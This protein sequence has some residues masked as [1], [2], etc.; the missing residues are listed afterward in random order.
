M[1]RATPFHVLASAWKAF[2]DDPVATVD[3]G[4]DG[5]AAVFDVRGAGIV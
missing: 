1:Q 2:H 4:W 5:E 3:V